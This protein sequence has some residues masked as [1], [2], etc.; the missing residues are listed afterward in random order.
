MNCRSCG[1]PMKT[2]WRRESTYSNNPDDIFARCTGHNDECPMSVY[3]FRASTYAS[4]SDEHLNRLY[5][6]AVKSL[7]RFQIRARQLPKTTTS[8]S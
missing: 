4:L 5:R 2:F 3:E 8:N 7:E 6:Q 1:R